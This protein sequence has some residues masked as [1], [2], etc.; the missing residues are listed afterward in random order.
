MRPVLSV[1]FL[2]ACVPSLDVGPLRRCDVADPRV[3]C[4]T[5]PDECLNYFGADF[6]YCIEPGRE[7]GRCVECTVDEHCDLDSYCRQD[8]PEL[9]PFCAPLPPEE[10]G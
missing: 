9:G 10:S 8:L 1:L 4:C 2:L 6:P 5:A 7:T 3:D